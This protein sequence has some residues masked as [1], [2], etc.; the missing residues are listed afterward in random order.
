MLLQLTRTDFE[1]DVELCVYIYVYTHTQIKKFG[2]RE[3][4]LDEIAKLRHINARKG[5]R[6][7]SEGRASASLRPADQA[8]DIA[9]LEQQRQQRLLSELD[10]LKKKVVH[11]RDAEARAK[12]CICMHVCMYVC[13]CVCVCVCVT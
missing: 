1:G 10:M 13:V 9:R 4:L 12:V 11:M 5:A 2:Q 7:L 6:G 8:D 3:L